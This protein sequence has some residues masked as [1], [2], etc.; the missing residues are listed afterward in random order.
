MLQQVATLV[1]IRSDGVLL[2]RPRFED[3]GLPGGKVEGDETLQEALHREVM[4]ETGLTITKLRYW[5]K[6]GGITPN[7]QIP[8]L[9]HAHFGDVEGTPVPGRE[10]VQVAWVKNPDS[11]SLTEPCRQVWDE[12]IKEGHLD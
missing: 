3:W 12:L 9:A 1:S 5:R 4:Q 6:F 7:S 11:I 2:V 10:V 8:V